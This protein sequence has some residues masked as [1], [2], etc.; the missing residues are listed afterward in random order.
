MHCNRTI[1]RSIGSISGALSPRKLNTFHR[2]HRLQ[3]AIQIEVGLQEPLLCPCRL[4]LIQ[5][6]CMQSQVLSI[7]VCNVPSYPAHSFVA[8]THLSAL[9]SFLLISV[10]VSTAVLKHCDQQST[11]WG[12]GHFSYD[13][14]TTLHSL[15]KSGQQVKAV[16]WNR[17]RG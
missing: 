2:S 1:Y 8:G 3:I 17:S 14:Q 6:L 5:A 10:M 4:N 15:G 9:P 7:H 12:G 16:T 11:T 13:S